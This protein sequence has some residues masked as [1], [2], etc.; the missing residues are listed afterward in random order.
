MLDWLRILGSIVLVDLV[1]SGDNALVIGAVA[2]G[3]KSSVR[4]VAFIVGGGGAILLRILLTYFLTMLLQVP[5]L[6]TVGALILL[7]VAARL[8][9]ERN[10]ANGSHEASDVSQE[11]K[12]KGLPAFLTKNRVL[13]GIFTILA[14]D[15]TTSLDNIVAIAALAQDNTALLI[16]GLL[17]SVLLLL[18]GSAIV[19]RLI[20][21]LPWLILVA[22][23]ILTITAA[24][25]IL[26]DNQLQD[27]IPDVV[28]ALWV[29]T[30]VYAL[31]I[32][33]MMVPCYIWLRNHNNN[34]A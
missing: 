9:T 22:G 1:L 5:Y 32:L 26:Q 34:V 13:S 23:I 12:K 8:L 7:F 20:I 2:A 33:V 29:N 31:V 15:A 28:S 10:E 21:R 6:E 3:M 16:T 27:L 4:W 11:P 19:S 14:A 17:M 30:A 18:V 25:L 24:Q